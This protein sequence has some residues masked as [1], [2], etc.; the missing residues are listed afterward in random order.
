MACQ[1]YDPFFDPAVSA[2]GKTPQ[3]QVRRILRQGLNARKAAQD[4]ME[5]LEE[6][7]VGY[8]KDVLTPGIHEAGNCGTVLPAA[9][10]PPM[11]SPFGINGMEI[12]AHPDHRDGWVET[13]NI[14]PR[15]ALHDP[16]IPFIA[17]RTLDESVPSRQQ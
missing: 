14:V 7:A 15:Q 17:Q 10:H 13:L 8:D 11:A 5:H 9:R 12:I 2:Q 4:T 3:L 16:K 6:N 1:F